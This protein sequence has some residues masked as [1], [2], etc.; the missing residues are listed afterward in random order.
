MTTPAM[1]MNFAGRDS[2]T[3]DCAPRRP[4]FALPALIRI[5]EPN[6]KQQKNILC[7]LIILEK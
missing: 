3:G 7:I 4:L 2:A 1:R 5:H 6:S